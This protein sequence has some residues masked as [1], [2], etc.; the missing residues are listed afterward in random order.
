MHVDPSAPPR[1]YLPQPGFGKTGFVQR[2]VRRLDRIELA[3]D[4]L[5]E[6]VAALRLADRVPAQDPSTVGHVPLWSAAM[7]VL[8]SIEWVFF[9]T[10]RRPARGVRLGRARIDRAG[11]PP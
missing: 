6:Q 2:D 4:P 8:L 3:A 7:I 5:D 10:P 1:R 11:V 9:A